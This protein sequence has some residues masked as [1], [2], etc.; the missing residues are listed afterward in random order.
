MRLMM[1]KSHPNLNGFKYGPESLISLK[2]IGNLIILGVSTTLY[3]TIPK[4]FIARTDYVRQL[5]IEQ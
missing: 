4:S 5:H 3:Y 1:C 2:T